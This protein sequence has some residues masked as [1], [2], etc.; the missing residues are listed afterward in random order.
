MLTIINDILDFSKIEAGKLQ[1]QPTVF[2]L[3]QLVEDVGGMF[4]EQAH[5]KDLNLACVFPADAHAAYE[6]DPDR[7]RQVLTNLVG[8]ALKFTEHGEVVLRAACTEQGD[9]VVA[10]FEVQDTGIG[11][12]VENQAK[13]FDSFTQADASTSRKFGGTGL[14]LSICKQLT[15]LMGGE[16]GLRSNQDVGSTFWFTCQLKR[17][18]ASAIASTSSEIGLKNRRVL[19]VDDNQTNLQVVEHQLR[20][21][22]VDFCAAHTGD[23]AL[24]ALRAS[25]RNGRPIELVICD[26]QVPGLDAIGLLNAIRSDSCLPRPYMLMLCSIGSLEDTGQ[27]M[28]A[29]MD[30][31]LNKPVRQVELYESLARAFGLHDNTGRRTSATDIGISRKFEAHVLVVEDNPLNQ[32]LAISMLAVLGCRTKLA[33]NGREAVEAV[34]SSPLDALQD[35]YDLVL[36]DCQMPVMDGYAATGAIRDWEASRG[37]D[38]ALP[39]V[40]LTANAMQGDRE[41][42]LAAGMTDYL[43]KPFSQQQLAEVLS[44]WLPLHK[45][46]TEDRASTQIQAKTGE[47]QIAAVTLDQDALQQI[48]ALQRDGEPCI[49]SKVFKIYLDTSPALINEL[50]SAVARLD[51]EQ[52]HRTAHTL[53]SSSANVGA[54]TLAGLCKELESM[55]RQGQVNE[56]TTRIDILDFEFE[57]VCRALQAEM[58]ARA[59]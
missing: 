58:T 56:A 39:I 59:A 10:R 5:R 21:W 19:M 17:M 35:P 26:K 36:M 47:A 20:V 49:L 4:A 3:R 25:A 12:K 9:A 46:Q 30:S 54:K 43:A 6:G 38:Q 37:A 18:P 31:Y 11:I 8:N 14:G 55:G 40:A 27:W 7:I 32:E 34:A 22:G 52:L 41:R 50:R 53:K 44:R 33:G 57:T 15:G 2:D 48:K 13:I 29:G 24:S 51:S 23:E 28:I 42:C 45:T 1:L 16:I